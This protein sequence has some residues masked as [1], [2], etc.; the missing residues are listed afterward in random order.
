MFTSFKDRITFNDVAGFKEAK[1]E[2][3]EVVDFLKKYRWSSFKD[4]FG[5]GGT[6]TIVNKN[7]F[8]ELFS[9]KPE[10]Y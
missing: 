6:E 5:K 10:T 4:Y 7:L 8:Y 1:Q 3:E 9:S 2:L